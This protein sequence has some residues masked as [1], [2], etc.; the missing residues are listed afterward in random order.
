[1]DTLILPGS[2]PVPAG[3][4]V[5][6]TPF[7]RE[8]VSR[9]VYI[10]L[11][12]EAN[13]LRPHNR[14]LQ[15]ENEALQARRE[16]EAHVG[17]TRRMDGLEDRCRELERD[18]GKAQAR[19]WKKMRF[20][21]SS[22]KKSLRRGV[23]R[24]PGGPDLPAVRPALPRAAGNRRLR[25]PGIRCPA[26]GPLGPADPACPPRPR[27]RGPGGDHGTGGAPRDSEGAA[28]RVGVD[29]DA[30]AAVPVRTFHQSPAD[31]EEASGHAAVAESG[32][33]WAGALPG[34]VRALV[35]GV[36]E[37]PDGQVGLPR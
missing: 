31:R 33:R 27:C 16:G 23:V 3:E 32:V 15:A 13:S 35:R 18:R 17:R 12:T 28:G 25:D 6:G 30:A 21:L 11:Q 2:A 8:F 10:E 5:V 36:A 14:R 22:E 34:P 20:G 7:S 19:Q 4:P 1:M 29:R 9:Q 37:A 26:G 24:G